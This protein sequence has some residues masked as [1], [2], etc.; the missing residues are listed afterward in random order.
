MRDSEQERSLVDKSIVFGQS[1][2]GKLACFMFDYTLDKVTIMQ[3][4]AVN[5]S[6]WKGYIE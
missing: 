5:K 1:G 6:R 2:Q 3:N 4:N